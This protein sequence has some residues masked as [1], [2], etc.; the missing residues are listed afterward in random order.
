MVAEAFARTAPPGARA[1]AT[2]PRMRPAL[3][4]AAVLLLCACDGYKKDVTTVCNARA[5]AGVAADA[6]AEEQA[7]ALTAYLMLNVKTKKAKQLFGKMA[8]RP[9]AEQAATLA[10]EA[11]SEGVS[12]CPLAEEF[13]APK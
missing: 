9:P 11:K 12:P 13:A 10:R 4:L 6:G 1:A 7:Q 3:L 8:S 5:K 2:V